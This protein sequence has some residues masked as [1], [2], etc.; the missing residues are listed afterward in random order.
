MVW[1]RNTRTAST[2]HGS[3]FAS[4][5]A[6]FAARTYHLALMPGVNRRVRLMIDWTVALF[7][8]RGS[9]ELGQ[10]G[11]PPPLAGEATIPEEITDSG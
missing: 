9:P 2:E 11:H 10:L 7:F 4:F 1:A 5:T 8:S 3:F 6:W